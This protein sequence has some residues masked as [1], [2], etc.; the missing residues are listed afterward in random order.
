[1][2]GVGEG[3][4]AV[5]P[6]PAMLTVICCRGSA[7]TIYLTLMP[8]SIRSDPL[9]AP[10]AGRI[11]PRLAAEGGRA[12]HAVESKECHRTLAPAPAGLP[13]H[14]TLIS[15]RRTPLCRTQR[16]RALVAGG[17]VW[18]MYFE[19]L[20][21]TIGTKEA[22]VSLA[23][24]QADYWR[25][26]AGELEKRSP[27]AVERVLTERISIREAE[28]VRLADDREQ[29]SQELNRVE[30]EVAVL[31]RTLEQTKGF[32]EMLAMEQPDPD[33][34][35]YEEYLE[36]IK[37]RDN[38]V[39]EVEIAYLG[40]VGVDSGQLLITDPCYIDSEWLD[41]PFQDDRVYRDAQTGATVATP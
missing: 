12:R 17:V 8:E 16:G 11:W 22:E 35:N 18:K 20:K 31:N 13:V 27:E 21:A 2:G 10:L 19:N 32:R 9:L 41:E 1:M 37:N 4:A 15:S 33:D 30:Q 23:S 40:T 26:K 29:G 28:I 25:E 7:W 38:R 6:W 5:C 24:K 39:V 14:D 34:P 36:Y 3:A